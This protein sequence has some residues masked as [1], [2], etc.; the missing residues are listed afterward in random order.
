[1]GPWST[2]L[3]PYPQESD[4]ACVAH[5]KEVDPG[6]KRC[7]IYANFRTE[8]LITPPQYPRKNEK[9][10]NVHLQ[11]GRQAPLLGSLPL[12]FGFLDFHC[13]QCIFT[14]SKL[15]PLG[16]YGQGSSFEQTLIHFTQRFFVPSLFEIGRVVL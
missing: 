10:E 7:P 11:S 8:A 5:H 9:W 12:G 14:I 6:S 4:G 1:M 13:F 2:S 16:N 15:S 3:Y